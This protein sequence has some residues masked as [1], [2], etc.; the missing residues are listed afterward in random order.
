MSGAV[1][2]ECNKVEQRVKT[3]EVLMAPSEAARSKNEK[4]YRTMYGLM[5]ATSL[6]EGRIKFPAGYMCCLDSLSFLVVGVVYSELFYF[7][8][9]GN[10]YCFLVGC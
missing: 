1:V 10:Y 2:S 6:R 9:S 4:A 7:L 5:K 3:N 8:R